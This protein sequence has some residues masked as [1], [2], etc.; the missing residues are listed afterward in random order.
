M[1]AASVTAVTGVTD[2]L[3]ES[4]RKLFG[5]QQALEQRE[6]R[7]VFLTAT[8]ALIIFFGATVFLFV[9]IRRDLRIR[10]SLGRERDATR[11]FLESI[12]SAI[13]HPILI[14]EAPGLSYTLANPA[15]ATL[16]GV[17]L[18]ET[19]DKSD[20][21]FFP[22]ERAERAA[23]LDRAALARGTLTTA[24]VR[25][26]TAERGER[27]FRAT[28]LPFEDEGGE[29]KYLLTIAEDISDFLSAEERLKEMN[30]TLKQQA[31]ELRA[32]VG[33][34]SSFSYTVSHDLR[35][36]LRAMD[37]F[38][39][40]LAEDYGERLDDAGKRYISIIRESSQRMGAL[41]DAL[42][43]Y[44]RIGREAPAIADVDMEQL[45]KVARDEA[46]SV[47]PAV[48]ATWDIARLPEA[49][50]DRALL[51]QVWINLLTNALKFAQK[52]AAPRIEIRGVTQGREVVYSVKDNGVGFDMKFSAKLFG[53][54]QRLHSEDLYCGAGVG[55]AV[56]S[57]IIAHHAGRVWAES[58]PG[59]GATFYFSLPR[60]DRDVVA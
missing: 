3:I 49:A 23:A 45:I 58:A 60:V 8:A 21:N 34:L 50:G 39:E 29:K 41:I 55:L 30:G 26:P 13:P 12:I 38:A 11:R 46:C 17:P 48:S 4:E 20:F 53:L 28:R 5:E 35:T 6:R 1:T 2:A 43:Y 15:M 54:F 22:R 56:V 19:L 59:T 57:R 42:L 16:I 7:T 51:K 47:Y 33:E 36:P 40:M 32:A 18:Q 31:Q 27:T 25:V 52:A 10:T 9:H 24:V 37:G 44:T 14:K